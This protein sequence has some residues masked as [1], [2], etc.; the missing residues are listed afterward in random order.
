MIA[1]LKGNVQ[2]KGPTSIVLDVRGVGYLVHLPVRIRNLFEIGQDV[3]LQIHTRFNKDQGWTLIGF[4]NQHEKELFEAL[5]KVSKVGL[6]IALAVLDNA[7]PA[8]IARAIL[9]KDLKFLSSCPGV[10]KKTAERICLELKDK[11][12]KISAASPG[13]PD[14]SGSSPSWQDLQSALKNMGYRDHEIRDALNSMQEDLSQEKLVKKD[15]SDLIREALRRML[16][17]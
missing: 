8:A 14:T 5:I 15:L 13:T 10:G 12:S 4:T 1:F 11:I 17:K 9:S 7:E 2:D 3:E 16:S 6:K